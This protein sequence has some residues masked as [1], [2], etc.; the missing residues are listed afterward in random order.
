MIRPPNPGIVNLIGPPNQEPIR[1]D[2]AKGDGVDLARRHG[3]PL[4]DDRPRDAQDHP[5]ADGQHG[6]RAD[7]AA[8]QGGTTPL[9]Y[10][11]TSGRDYAKSPPEGVSP[12]R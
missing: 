11:A 1:A 12:E 6:P 10:N 5:G 4:E 8:A 7:D 2:G 3:G 9:P